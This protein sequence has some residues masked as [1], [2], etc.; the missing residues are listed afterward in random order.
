[1]PAK[2]FPFKIGADPEFSVLLGT[3]KVDASNM[4]KA[5]L[6]GKHTST[7][8][9]YDIDKKANIGWDGCSS[10]GEV[11]PAPSSDPNE[12]VANIKA[13]FQSIT[14]KTGIFDFSTSSKMAP[15]GG[16]IH[17]ELVNRD[18]ARSDASMELI[19]R[20][21]SAFY[22]P[23]LLGEDIEDLRHRSGDGGGGYGSINDY[24]VEE[25]DGGVY[26]Y[27][28]RVPSAEWLTTPKVARAT[29]AYVATVFA[30]VIKNPKA[31]MKKHSDIIWKTGKQGEALQKMFLAEF[32]TPLSAMI[33]K[34]KTSIRKFEFYEEY[35]SEIEYILRPKAVLKEKQNAGFNVVTGWKI[36][37]KSPT[38]RELLTD[39]TSK[40]KAGL[41]I[42]SFASSI[43]V[44]YN[45]DTNVNMFATELKKKIINLGWKLK[46]QYF[47]FGLHKGVNDFIAF[48]KLSEI[49]YDGKQIVTKKDATA[50]ANI[51]ERISGRFNFESYNM[52]SKE[53]TEK[54]PTYI[55]VGIPYEMR[56][57][58]KMKDFIKMI[59]EIEA[60]THKAH[61]INPSTL[62]ASTEKAPGEIAAIYEPREERIRA[63]VLPPPEGQQITGIVTPAEAMRSI[64]A[65]ASF[66]ET[67]MKRIDQILDEILAAD[68]GD[69]PD[70]ES[71]PQFNH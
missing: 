19:H 16:H 65:A 15:V 13:A 17:L 31:F 68:L 32:T 70:F 41:D 53:K 24:R 9:G 43:Y 71:E 3:K 21:M 44:P 48:N 8:M 54:A 63:G 45:D 27:E 52:S 62:T 26:T 14:E 29:L 2:T 4:I 55:M 37:M 49:V 12:V 42:D 28:F 67:E 59:Y 33:K 56:V 11:R 51:I 35:K 18:T 60:G 30:E 40:K 34:A 46:N 66:K 25:R 23:V 5:V 6:K 47:L 10:T 61:A 22:I 58:G 50:V 57:D 38:K 36:G 39:K 64:S 1:M 7:S 20:C 69:E